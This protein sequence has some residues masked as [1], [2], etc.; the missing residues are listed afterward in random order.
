MTS[1]MGSVNWAP[2]PAWQITQLQQLSANNQLSGLPPQLLAVIVQEESG[3]QG[4]GINPSGDGGYFGL[5]QSATY[6]GGNTTPGLLRDTSV[7]SF[8]TQAQIA[9]SAF[10]GY[11]ATTGGNLLNAE[12]IYQTGQP[13]S[14]GN[15]PSGGTQLVAQYFGS[16]TQLT[17]YNAQT[18]SSTSGSANLGLEN[19]CRPILQLGPL[20]TVIDA[21]Q[22]RTIK[23]IAFMA[24]GGF[25][26][27]VGLG[28]TFGAIGLSRSPAKTLIAALPKG[29]SSS[30]E[31]EEI[32]AGSITESVTDPGDEIAEAEGIAAPGRGGN[33]GGPGARSTMNRDIGGSPERYMAA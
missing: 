26:V 30:V 22:A 8:S 19:P 13:I 32:P 3:G 28:I 11:L 4:G 27:L 20:G 18:T 25:V 24:V 23:S 15:P 12:Q 33:K 14:S 10:A 9:A 29:R 2:I 16:S 6:P 5:Q 1:T 21:A 7:S 17:G 31:V